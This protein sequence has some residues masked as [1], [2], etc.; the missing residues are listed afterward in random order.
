MVN[1]ILTHDKIPQAIIVRQAPLSNFDKFLKET[2]KSLV[3]PEHGCNKCAVCKRIDDG[4]YFDLIVFDAKEGVSKDE[5]INLINRFNMPPTEGPVKVYV[6][7]NIEYARNRMINSLLKFVEEPPKDVYAIFTTRNYNA[8]L[9]T[10]RSRCFNIYLEKDEKLIDEFLRQTDL[11]PGEKKLIKNCFYTIKDMKDNLEQ[12]KEF[13]TLINNLTAANGL[14]Y[15]SQAQTVFKSITYQDIYLFIDICKN[16]FPDLA[17]K[18]I[19]IQDN[20]YL[21]PNKSLVFNQIYD[22][23]K[24]V[25]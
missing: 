23:L 13:V 18:F 19:D 4:Y 14:V 9:P 17:I 25:R 6:I 12:F 22:L 7:K 20:L 3:C 16:M 5:I 1:N 11:K 2:V 24:G 15:A 10:I 21:N 8:I